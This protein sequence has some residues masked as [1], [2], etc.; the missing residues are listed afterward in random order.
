MPLISRFPAMSIMEWLR[1]IEIHPPLYYM[2]TKMV[3]L[4]NSSDT[5]LRLLSTIPGIL[6]IYVIYRIGKE[7][8][9]PGAGLAACALLAVNPYALW[10][11]RIV[12]PYSLFL[13]FFLL[14]LWALSRWMRTGS[15]QALAGLLAANL[16]LFWTHYIMVV[17]AP[18]FGLLV[19]VRSWPRL[20]SFLAFTAA[21]T[22][23]FATIL[24][25]FLQN[26]R[27]PHWLGSASPLEILTD[28]GES[29]LKLLWFFPGPVVWVM[30]TLA[31]MGL[32]QACRRHKAAFWAGMVLC[33][34]PVLVVVAGKLGWTHEPRYFLF[35]MP[36][37][38]LFAGLGLQW[39]LDCLRA[40]LAAWSSLA[41]AVALGASILLVHARSYYDADTYFGLDWIRYKA[42]A[43]VIP[44]LV[45]TGEPV[46]VS[47]DGL[48]NALDWYLER[49][50]VPNPLRSVKIS[51]QDTE[52]VTNF[53]WFENMGH[54]AQTEPELAKAFPGLVNAGTVGGLTFY[55]A[56]IQRCPV[57][58]A[59]TIPWE[60]RFAGTRDILAS[61]Q[62]MEGLIPTPFW[63]GELEA[64]ANDA[65][66][67]VEYAVDNDSGQMPKS[68][69]I[70]CH[71]Q[72]A[73]TGNSLRVLTRFNDESWVESFTSR[74]PDQY[75]YRRIILDR[76]RP[77]K[78]LTV[79]VEMTCAMITAQYPGGN[80]GSLT[81]RD[82]LIALNHDR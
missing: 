40:P 30:L 59:T 64:G 17:L 13:F 3:M 43:C 16:V 33:F 60:H 81:L 28:V 45:K 12:R 39:L 72:N 77:F 21:T 14:A 69:E 48:Q 23:S 31:A 47:E 73:G 58:S 80:L 5:S 29:S 75:F 79:R 36:V 55:K 68:L 46:V 4:A 49:R 41:V 7:A 44:A 53:L 76:D 52:V 37:G 51:P 70:T 50:Q 18:A 1:S 6:S 15:R 10:L 78:R 42:A 34:V 11:S 66:G 9:G 57:Q 27:R 71:Y 22:L 82:V 32:I 20:R 19:L 65:Q 62:A 61:C 67:F 74:G 24:P 54:L 26:F 56:A 63:G 38:L 25:F 35:I 2:L 8:F